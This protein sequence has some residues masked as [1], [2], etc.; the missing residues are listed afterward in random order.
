MVFVAFNAFAIFFSDPN[1]FGTSTSHDSLIICWLVFTKFA[2]LDSFV[3]YSSE[4][5]VF[6]SDG[7]VLWLIV[8]CFVVMTNLA[9]LRPSVSPPLPPSVL[10]PSGVPGVLRVV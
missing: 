1:E 2:R 10:P 8:S 7:S 9:S 6:S 5:Y 4:S 3:R